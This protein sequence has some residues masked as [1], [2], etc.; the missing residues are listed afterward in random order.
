MVSAVDD[1]LLD[2]GIVRIRPNTD[3]ATGTNAGAA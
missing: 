3:T 2:H 1:S